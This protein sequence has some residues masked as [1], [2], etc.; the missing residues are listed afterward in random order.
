MYDI[1]KPFQILFLFHKTH[2]IST[3]NFLIQLQLPVFFIL[4][5]IVHKKILCNLV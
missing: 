3:G 5:Q 2:I 1:I 4:T